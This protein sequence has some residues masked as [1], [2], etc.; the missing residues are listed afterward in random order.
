MGSRIIALAGADDRFEVV[1]AIDQD[2]APPARCGAH[3]VID[4]SSDSGVRRA[5]ALSLADG[6]ALLVGT[7]ALSEETRRLLEESGQSVPVMV[8]PNMSP[9]VAVLADLAAR[10]ARILGSGYAIDIVES[11]HAAKRDAPSGTALR[12]ADAVHRG[13]GRRLPA[14]RLHSLRGGDVVGEHTVRLAGPGEYLELSHTATS[15]DLFALGA[16][17]A[18][19]WLV[20]QPPGR[21]TIEDEIGLG[22]E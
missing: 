20:R 7:T 9:G 5:A 2:D 13:G 11:H 16:L 12:L 17:R 1:A 14:E 8:A 19:A 22:R 18:A 10:A 15:R 21:Y 3:A 6:A 4:F